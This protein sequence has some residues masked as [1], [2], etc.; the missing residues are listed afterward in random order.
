MNE[1][2]DNSN[3]NTLMKES[4]NPM[5]KIDF[6]LKEGI[7][8]STVFTFQT[9]LGK[10]GFGDVI[11]CLDH[12]EAFAHILTPIPIENVES[13]KELKQPDEQE[14]PE[15]EQMEK[16]VRAPMEWKP[17]VDIAIKIIE[18]PLVDFN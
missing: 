9:I 11:H 15:Q 2:E 17:P 10:G 16:V 1:S 18:K 6:E 7:R 12:T 4:N 5:D 13:S 14:K 3:N 8:F